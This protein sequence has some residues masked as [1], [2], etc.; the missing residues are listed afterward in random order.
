[1]NEPEEGAFSVADLISG[2]G[3]Q[4]EVAWLLFGNVPPK[5]SLKVPARNRS[6]VVFRSP[7]LGKKFV[8]K[9]FNHESQIKE[10]SQFG[11]GHSRR[12]KISRYSIK[13]GV[14]QGIGGQVGLLGGRVYRK[15]WVIVNLHCFFQ[16][17]SAW[18][19][20]D[21]ISNLSGDLWMSRDVFSERAFLTRFFWYLN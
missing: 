6:G 12:L 13:K 4:L 9:L 19:I 10:L 18:K 7:K 1:M 8:F 14:C 16:E 3:S 20:K 5:S 17:A 21:Y 2:S 11:D 15:G